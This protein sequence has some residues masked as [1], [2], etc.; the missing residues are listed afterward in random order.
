VVRKAKAEM[1]KCE[2]PFSAVGH[3]CCQKCKSEHCI[4]YIDM[5]KPTDDEDY[6]ACLLWVYTTTGS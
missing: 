6:G 1:E 3:R 5:T 2:C 4:H